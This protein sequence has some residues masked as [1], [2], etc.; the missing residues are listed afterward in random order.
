MVRYAQ[1]SLKNRKQDEKKQ[2]Q[3][4]EKQVITNENGTIFYSTKLDYYTK[5]A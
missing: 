2:K 5:L 1:R 4:Q 3:T